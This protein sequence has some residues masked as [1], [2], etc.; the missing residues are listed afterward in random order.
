MNIILIILVAVFLYSLLSIA[1]K[2]P[3]FNASRAFKENDQKTSILS[4]ILD[5]FTVK[6][7]P[8]IK[9]LVAKKSKL[10][11]L[12][13]VAGD[14][15]TPEELVAKSYVN[16][17][18]SLCL[19]PLL[20][21]ADPLFSVFAVLLAGYSYRREFNLVKEEGEK[22]QRNIEQEMLKF[23]MYMAN[24]IKT[25]K[26]II[27]C[28]ESYIM[29]FDTPLTQELTLTLAEMRVGNYE[30]AI[31]NMAQRNNSEA[32]S[33]LSSGLLS[34]MK[35]DDTTVHFTNLGIV[36]TAR[37]EETLV[38]QAKAKKPKI[39]QLSMI[40]FAVAIVTIGIVLASALSSSTL[41]FGGTI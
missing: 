4:D 6:L 26:N 7:T 35:G 39:T 23:V 31:K 15:R 17:L 37:W 18:A 3:S 30:Q 40:M 21:L 29:N 34:M 1:L 36:L 10:E 5:K 28:I 25:E 12:L 33:Q 11:K 2:I 27:T 20:F 14:T 8:K 9:L 24:A 41:L 22:R 19:A 13:T 38:R 32:M 16:V